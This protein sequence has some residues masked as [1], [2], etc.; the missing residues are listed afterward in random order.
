MIPFIY[1]AKLAEVLISE[2]AYRATKFISEKDVIKATRRGKIDRRNS[3]TEILFTLGTPNYI[4][5]EF[6][7]K[8]K[9]CGE[10]FPVK[11][12]LLKWPVRRKK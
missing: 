8:L 4:E 1:F 11:K 6:I 7:K 3:R 9:Q 10:P 12:I 2:G 5:R